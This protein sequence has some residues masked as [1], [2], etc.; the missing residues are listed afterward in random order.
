M[1]FLFQDLMVRN[2]LFVIKTHKSVNKLINKI[3][4]HHDRIPLG[5]TF[6]LKILLLLGSSEVLKIT[7]KIFS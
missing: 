5:K 2:E 6:D 7:V 3:T 4:I 1:V